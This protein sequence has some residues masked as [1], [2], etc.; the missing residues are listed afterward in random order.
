MQALDNLED[1]YEAEEFYRHLKN[2]NTL[3]GVETPDLK[4]EHNTLANLVAEAHELKRLVYYRRWSPI[5]CELGFY[6]LKE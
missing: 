6:I 4:L 2:L 5:Q 3:C 1:L